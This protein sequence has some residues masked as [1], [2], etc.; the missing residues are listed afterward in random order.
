PLFLLVAVVVLLLFSAAVALWTLR[1]LSVPWRAPAVLCVFGGLLAVLLH[2]SQSLGAFDIRVQ[3]RKYP[4]AG[5]FVRDR[6]PASAFVLAAQH[7]GSIRYYANRPT[8]RWDLLSPGRLDE[9]VATFRAQ[10]YE[11]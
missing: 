3:E 1:R 8:L 5:A 7:S 9:V 6:L 2:I 11:P 10:G 4:L